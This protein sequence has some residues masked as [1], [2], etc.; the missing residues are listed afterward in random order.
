MHS[1][2]IFAVLILEQV[3]K[4]TSGLALFVSKIVF[5]T[6]ASYAFGEVYIVQIDSCTQHFRPV[7]F[8]V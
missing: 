5:Y 3:N 2:I 6:M 8:F 1:K 4:Y 7:A